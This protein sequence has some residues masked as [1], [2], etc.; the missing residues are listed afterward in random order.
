MISNWLLACLGRLGSRQWRAVR[1]LLLLTTFVPA[2]TEAQG[3]RRPLPVGFT[4]DTVIRL[5]PPDSMA[6][7][8]LRLLLT[9]AAQDSTTECQSRYPYVLLGG[10]VGAIVGSARYEKSTKNDYGEFD[11]PLLSIP[12]TL[13]PYILGGMLLGYLLSPC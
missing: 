9:P 4:R 8:R 2:L 5:V 10:L 7:R 6:T 11:I 12:L 13:G 1:S 3:S